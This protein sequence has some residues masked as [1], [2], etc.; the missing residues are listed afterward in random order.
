MNVTY[1]YLQD[2]GPVITKVAVVDHEQIKKNY[3][4]ILYYANI[5]KMKESAQE[6]L[7][8][9]L[10][11]LWRQCAGK[12][13]GSLRYHVMVPPFE[14]MRF[15]AS[16]YSEELIE[17]YECNDIVF[18]RLAKKGEDACKEYLHTL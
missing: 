14:G 4:L 5:L 18:V 16:L 10:S 11:E 8:Q 15:M 12:E 6:S 9:I 17:T 13:I 2:N 7:Q 1:Y 3:L